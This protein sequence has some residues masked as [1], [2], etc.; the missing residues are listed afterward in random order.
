MINHF[1]RKRNQNTQLRKDFLIDPMKNY[2]RKLEYMD[3]TIAYFYYIS[4][5]NAFEHCFRIISE[6]YDVTLYESQK[7]SINRLFTAFIAPLQLRIDDRLDF[8]NVVIKIRNSIHNNGGF[9]SPKK[10]KSNF[11]II[12]KY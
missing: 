12:K 10:N 9:I 2:K 8:M 6:K 5:F 1:G 3:Q 11:L 4:I 7:K